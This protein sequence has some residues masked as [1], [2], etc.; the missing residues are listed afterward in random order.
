MKIT[1]SRLLEII[2]EEVA[3][4]NHSKQKEELYE[5]NVVDL[6]EM[7]DEE[8]ADKDDDGEISKQEFDDAIENDQVK[9]GDAELEEKK[10]AKVISKTYKGEKYK[11]T[12]GLAA[13]AKGKKHPKTA[14]AKAASSWAKEPYAVA[15]ATK[16]ATTGAPK[17]EV[18]FDPETKKEL[19]PKK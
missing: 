8:K 7:L 16:I 12:P 6:A 3:L 2:K 19:K 18:L 17:E 1:K 10:S 13:I 11:T 5:F 14:V 15:Q 9:H 4:Y